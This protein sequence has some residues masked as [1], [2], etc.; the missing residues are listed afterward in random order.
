MATGDG[1][2]SSR[3][4]AEPF[5][6]AAEIDRRE[7]KT[8]NSARDYDPNGVRKPSFVEKKEKYRYKGLQHAPPLSITRKNV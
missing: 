1:R 6:L 7:R 5:S 4:S 3:P 2:V 8:F